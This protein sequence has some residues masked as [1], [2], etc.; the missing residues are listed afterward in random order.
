MPNPQTVSCKVLANRFVV[1]GF[2]LTVEREDKIT[3]ALQREVSWVQSAYVVDSWIPREFTVLMEVGNSM[4]TA[5]EQERHQ[6][7]REV[8]G[9]TLACVGGNANEVNVSFEYH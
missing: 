4:R 5:T 2:L 7:F 1:K 6:M 9:T 3:R 8:V